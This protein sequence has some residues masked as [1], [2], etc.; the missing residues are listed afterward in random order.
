MK[1][2]LIVLLSFTFLAS[3]AARP[4]G[5]DANYGQYLA[6]VTATAER[7]AAVDRT[8]WT[9]TV[10]TEPVVLP[11]GTAIMVRVPPG[12]LP[13]PQMFRD[14]AYEAELAYYGQIW[15][16]VGGVAIP[17]MSSAWSAY[18]NRR[19]IEG[20]VGR[21]GTTATW[22]NTGD[23]IQMFSGGLGDRVGDYVETTTLQPF[24]VDPVVVPTPAPVIVNPVVVPTPGP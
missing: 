23:G 5:P 2:L 18:Q 3:C 16:I 21:V 24:A 4:V 8:I 20:I 12:P 10:G 11:A 13:Q 1:S 9:M 14:Y 22:N 19:M 17:A 15:S 6:A 7:E